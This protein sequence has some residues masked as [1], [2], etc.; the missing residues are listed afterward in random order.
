MD[1]TG[2]VTAVQ[3]NFYRVQLDQPQGD[4]DR[5]L[6]VRRARL[7]KIGQQVCVGDRVIIAEPDWQGQRGA[8]A[9]VLPRRNFL[10]RPAIANIDRLVLMFAFPDPDP[11][12]ISRF[13]VYGEFLQIPIVLCLNKRDL[14]DDSTWQQWHDRL[15]Q[16]GY[17]PLPLSVEQGRGIDRLQALLQGGIAILAGPSGV[18]KSSLINALIPQQRVATGTVNP[19]YGSGR[20]TTRHV[21]LFDLPQGGKLADSPG[22]LQPRLPMAPPELG[23]CFPEIRRQLTHDRCEFKDCLHQGEPGCRVSRDWDRYDHYCQ[24]LAEVIAQ[25]QQEEATPDSDGELK[26]KTE[27]GGQ[28]RLEPRLAKKKYRRSSRRRLVQSLDEDLEGTGQT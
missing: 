16:W 19:K 2:L 26:A 4:I 14:V 11:V 13:L 1:L 8:I 22:F 6:C 25:Q 21:E 7:K 3:A 10:E 24:F 9:A 23:K 12:Q 20:H 15:S 28:A 27:K 17:E 18:G 5:L